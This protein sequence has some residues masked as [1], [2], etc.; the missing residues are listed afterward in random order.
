SN[1]GE[2]PVACTIVLAIDF[3]FVVYSDLRIDQGRIL[4]HVNWD[5]GCLNFVRQN[6]INPD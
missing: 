1:E 6:Q 3:G 2:S 5:L 4:T